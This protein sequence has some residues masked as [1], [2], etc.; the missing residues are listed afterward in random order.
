MNKIATCIMKKILQK[1]VQ[2]ICKF[3]SHALWLVGKQVHKW[4]C[5]INFK[6][7]KSI[8]IFL[9][10]KNPERKNVIQ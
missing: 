7:F 2:E 3:L 1:A 9:F 8:V 10:L 5:W 4:F 6:W